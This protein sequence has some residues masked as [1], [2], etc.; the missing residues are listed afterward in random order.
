MSLLYHHYV[1]IVMLLWCC[2]RCVAIVV[3]LRYC[4]VVVIVLLLCCYNVVL[5]QC[6]IV[7]LLLLPLYFHCF[8]QHVVLLLLPLCYFHCT[9]VVTTMSFPL[10]YSCYHYDILQPINIIDLQTFLLHLY[11]ARCSSYVH[12]CKLFNPFH[13]QCYTQDLDVGFCSMVLLVEL[14]SIQ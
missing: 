4:N 7:L 2:C 3:P 14:P 8:Q 6:C 12:I 11:V 5:P 10:H 13:I 9:I 1:A